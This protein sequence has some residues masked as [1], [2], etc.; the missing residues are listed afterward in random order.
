MVAVMA[1]LTPISNVQAESNLDK[2]KAAA[3]QQVE[4]KCPLTEEQEMA[5][6]QWFQ[7]RLLDFSS[8]EVTEWGEIQRSKKKNDT[9]I[10]IA[11]RYISRNRAGN[12]APGRMVFGMDTARNKIT[13]AMEGV[14]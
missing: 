10:V 6:Y 8:F 14:L 5:V 12:I 3:K 1:I 2:F 13:F 11:V 9:H 7:K 4:N